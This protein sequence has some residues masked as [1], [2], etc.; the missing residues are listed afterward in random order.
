M[1]LKEA[2]VYRFNFIMTIVTAP[3]AMVIFYFLWKSIFGY[4]GV[5]VIEGFTFELMVAYY[6]LNII[7]GFFIWSYVDTDLESMIIDGTLTPAL[8]RPL[9]YFW[10]TFS[11][12]MGFNLLSVFI[13]AI[14]V[15]IIAVIFFGV[16]LPSL[17]NGIFFVILLL[18]AIMINFIIAYLVGIT[19]FWLK[20][21]SG[22]RRVKR[23]VVAFL[24]GSFIPLSFFPD[25]VVNVSKFMPF[26]Y[27]RYIPVTV[28]LGNYNT[29][30]ILW[31][32]MIAAA[33]AVALYLF[34]GYLWKIAYKQFAGSGT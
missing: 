29:S 7:V 12:H 19:A 30:Q 6:A 11:E 13:E 20:E 23:V 5:K 17:A 4:S 1:G 31:F 33:W 26:Q 9:N 2:L 22:I 34:S 24:A 3:L 25:W 15:T 18:I 27:I 8:L 16:K 28:Y 10:K 32:V 21:I 14:P